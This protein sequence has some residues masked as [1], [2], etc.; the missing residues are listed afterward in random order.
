MSM[1]SMGNDATQN[2]PERACMGHAAFAGCDAVRAFLT[3]SVRERAQFAQLGADIERRGLY[4]EL[5]IIV[6]HHG[7]VLLSADLLGTVGRALLGFDVVP[8]VVD[9][10]A[11]E[12]FLCALAI[13]AP[14]R[15]VDIDCHV[16][17][18]LSVLCHKAIW[19]ICVWSW[20]ASPLRNAT[21]MTAIPPRAPGA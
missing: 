20:S 10:E 17:L 8:D 6:N 16:F 12:R 7:N 14:C 4:L 11:C 5:A 2:V 3:V 18:F 9:A 19:P 1:D 15:S 21:T 13:T